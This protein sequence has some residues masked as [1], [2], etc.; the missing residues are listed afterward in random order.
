MIPALENLV[1]SFK[2]LPTIGSKS[3][4]RLA[5]YLIERPPAEIQELAQNIL[6]IKER[7]QICTRCHNYSEGPLCPICQSSRRDHSVICIVNRPV[8]IFTIEKAGRY[9]GVYHVLGGLLSPIS[10]ITPETLHIASLQKR[11]DTEKPGEL[12]IGLGGST[13]AETTALYLA[14][15]F[16]N[17]GAKITRF[18][19]GLPAGTD[20]EYLDQM[21]LAQALEER[22]NIGY[23][24][25]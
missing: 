2:R 1:N 14:R 16:G 13:E 20:I 25:Q 18:A 21:T 23:T 8:D 19:R 4:W 24:T 10:G 5:M 6:E 15:I 12:I 9:R 7:I 11:I 3:A 22:T 17:C